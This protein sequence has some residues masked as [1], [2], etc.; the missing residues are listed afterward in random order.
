[1]LDP[2]HDFEQGG[3]SRPVDPGQAD[4]LAGMDADR[5]ILEQVFGSEL[6]GK[7]VDGK[8]GLRYVWA[9]IVN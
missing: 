3:F 1:M 8:H 4:F 7:L 9:E 6:D 5:D 2:G